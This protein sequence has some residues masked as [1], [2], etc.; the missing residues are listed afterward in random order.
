MAPARRNVV[1]AAL[2][3]LGIAGMYL[4]VLYGFKC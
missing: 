3:I 2:L 4:R 1:L